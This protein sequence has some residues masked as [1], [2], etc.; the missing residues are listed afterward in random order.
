MPE[1]ASSSGGEGR[2]PR[3]RALRLALAA[4][5][6]GCGLMPP[7]QPGQAPAQQTPLPPEGYRLLWSDEFSGTALD[8]SRWTALAGPRR[9]SE[10]TPNAV[11]VRNGVLVMTTYT[12]GA[13]HHTAFL[14]TEGKLAATYGYI[15]ARIRFADAPG[16]WCSFW[17]QSP[18]NGEPKGDPA[19]AGVEIDV[20]EHRATDQSGW[21][22][23]KDLVALNLNWDGYG[24]DRQNRQKVT[25]L[26]DGAA[27]Q[28]EW[29]TYG[30][31]WTE[32]GYT[33]Y[34]DG[35]V[36]WEIDEGVSRRSEELELTCEVADG[37]WAGN[38]PPGGYGPR[39]TSTTGMQVD[40][41]RVWQKGP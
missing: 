14:S 40:W 22:A 20:V 26:P 17:L 15:E 28:G 27:L 25:G 18:T 38:V 30:V 21:T 35:V 11:A 9:D 31:L 36:L 41:V 6:A 13:G 3:G 4:L 32:S 12:D 24:P 16:E 8:P 34:L 5:V 33:F 10:M 2:R 7:E 29:H 37:S 19:R 39:A 23:L 1:A